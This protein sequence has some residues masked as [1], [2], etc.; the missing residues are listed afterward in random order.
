MDQYNKMVQ[1]KYK[2]KY[3]RLKK[4]IKEYVFENA[5]LCD[6]I[7]EIQDNIIV[8]KE[9]RRILMR[10]L[11]EHENDNDPVPPPTNCPESAIPALPPLK[12]MPKKRSNSDTS[13][14][15]KTKQSATGSDRSPQPRKQILQTIS[16]DSHGNPVYPVH[17]GNLTIHSIGE[18]VP[19][20]PNFHTENWIYPVGYMAT[21]VYSHPKEPERKCTFT[22]KILDNSGIPQFQIIP[23]SDF[24]HVFFGETAN[25]CHLALLE[26]I[27]RASDVKNLPL[28]AQGEL[29]FGLGNSTVISLLQANPNMRRCANFKGFQMDSFG[30]EK[31]SDPTLNYDALQKL[32]AISAYHTVPEIKEEP[33]DELLE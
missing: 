17:M 7:A 24:D 18:I 2:N 31:D 8:L 14:K 20:N 6:Q 21:R 11:L 12:K 23:D 30:L 22:C 1:M 15:S 3:R 10:K 16:V 26:T 29:F 27:V 28:G 5:S 25:V 4:V 13:S 33:P 32:I 19:D 9:E